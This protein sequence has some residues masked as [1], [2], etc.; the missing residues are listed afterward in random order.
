MDPEVLHT[1]LQKIGY[2]IELTC[3][4]QETGR[5]GNWDIVVQE[6]SPALLDKQATID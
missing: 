6:K 1:C 2:E 5:K 4:I 3:N